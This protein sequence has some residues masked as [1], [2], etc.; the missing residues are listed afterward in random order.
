MRDDVT[1]HTVEVPAG[2]TIGYRHRPGDVPVVLVHG[3]MTSSKHWDLVLESMDDDFDLYAV[4]LRGFGES[5]YREPVGAI[6]DFAADVAGVVDAV[7]LDRFHLVGWSA[8]GAVAMQVAADLPERVHRLV[9]LAPASTRGYPVYRKDETGQPTDEPLTTREEIRRDPVQVAPV[10]EAYEDCDAETL[11]GIWNRLIYVND[12]PDPDRYDDYVA[13]M[14][15]Q[16]NLVDVDYALAHFNVSTEH[17][18]IEPGSGA[19]DRIEAPALVLRGEDDLVV[20]RA[21]VEQTVADLGDCAELRHLPGCGH[22]PLVDDLDRFL[23]HVE[24]FLRGPG[25]GEGEGEGEGT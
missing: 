8:G 13:D 25:D 18:G 2:E 21:M 22:S 4:D 14:C 24:G 17:N 1:L 15:T 11:K 6:D 20:S 3:N 5:S 19:V 7:G 12:R 9:L 10:L 23:E 16:R